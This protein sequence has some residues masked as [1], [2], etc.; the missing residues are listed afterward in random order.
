MT[1]L[2][3]HDQDPP[4][5]DVTTLQRRVLLTGVVTMVLFLVAG[6]ALSSLELPGWYVLPI[7]VLLYA[8]VVRPMMQ[9]VRNAVRLRRD[10]AYQAFLDQR[11]G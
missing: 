10:L 6:V 2:P 4:L 5:L 3:G 8:F 11:R 7:A 1:G 9:P